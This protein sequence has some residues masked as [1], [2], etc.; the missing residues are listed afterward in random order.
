MTGRERGVALLAM[1]LALAVA[2]ALV[3]LM[4]GLLTDIEGVAC[5]DEFP[6]CTTPTQRLVRG[7][8]AAACGFGIAGML[9]AG[10]RIWTGSRRR[11][12]YWLVVVVGVLTGLMLVVDPAQ[13][14]TI[15][16]GRGQWFTW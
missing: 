8:L 7:V 11:N 6:F 3:S 4:I 15:D 14:M 9:V 12:A 16:Q 10:R 5:G 2:V 13:H 1:L